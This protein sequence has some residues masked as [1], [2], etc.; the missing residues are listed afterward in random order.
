MMEDMNMKIKKGTKDE[1]GNPVHSDE[2]KQLN[3]IVIDQIKRI[4]QKS[5]RSPI[6]HIA[7]EGKLPDES[8]PIIETL[9]LIEHELLKTMSINQELQQL[10][11]IKYDLEIKEARKRRKKERSNKAQP[12]MLDEQK[13]KKLR[14]LSK[15][16]KKNNTIVYKGRPLVFRARKKRIV[17]RDTGIVV[18]THSTLSID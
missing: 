8:K 1:E 5:K 17:K 11:P 2:P 12:K 15:M 10:H 13:A 6:I 3:K 9:R 4:H 7:C 18:S 14:N 16:D